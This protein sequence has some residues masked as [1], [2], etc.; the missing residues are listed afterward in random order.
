MPFPLK[1]FY[2]IRHGQ[3]VANKIG[4]LAGGRHDSQLT[5]L[6]IQQ[7]ID[8]RAAFEALPLALRPDVIIHSHLS[9]AHDT[10]NLLNRHLQ[11]PMQCDPDYGEMDVGDFTLQPNAMWYKLMSGDATASNG[12]TIQEFFMRI[13]LC[14]IKTLSAGHGLP[15]IVCHGGVFRAFAQAYGLQNM[16]SE[17]CVLHYFEP[18]ETHRAFPWHVYSYKLEG[19]TLKKTQLD[20]IIVS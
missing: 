2:M 7:A 13:K 20:F 18:D 4:R 3:S 16:R 12:E 9:R 10:A 8:A 6:G 1:P 19:E 15:L 17:N 14:K 11:L 5:P